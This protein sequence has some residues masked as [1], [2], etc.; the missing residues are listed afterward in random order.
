MSEHFLD[1]YEPVGLVNNT[2]VK[3]PITT[4]ADHISIDNN[5]DDVFD[6]I[7]SS[8]GA[9]AMAEN[10][11]GKPDTFS[12]NI[13]GLYEG[14]PKNSCTAVIVARVIDKIT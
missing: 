8:F 10:S 11:F 4:R 3:V 5:A 1:E 9:A 13:T 12:T 2:E 6:G 7:S 14:C